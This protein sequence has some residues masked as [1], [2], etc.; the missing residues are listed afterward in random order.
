MLWGSC[1]L[2]AC[3][4]A[5]SSE[6]GPLQ[7]QLAAQLEAS[8]AEGGRY[9]KTVTNLLEPGSEPEGQTFELGGEA[10]LLKEELTY[11]LRK[12]YASPY[13]RDAFTTSQQGDT[14]TA[15]VRTDQANEVELQAQRL[16]WQGPDS[17]LRYVES[18]LE[19]HSWLYDM[20]I[21]L[22]AHFDSLGHYQR[23]Q[24]EVMTDIPLIGSDFHARIEGRRE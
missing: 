2:L 3:G 15:Q 10:C 23:H 17:L 8:C 21:D 7:Q 12:Y 24:L 9:Q 4:G 5:R 13:L 6:K 1:L 20:R 11:A 18:H 22:V 14:L 19:K 16:V